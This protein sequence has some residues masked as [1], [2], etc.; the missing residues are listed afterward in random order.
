MEYL[1]NQVIDLELQKKRIAL[2]AS[3]L[4]QKLVSVEGHDINK[5]KQWLRELS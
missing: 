4:L 1:F 5:I 3:H 2:D